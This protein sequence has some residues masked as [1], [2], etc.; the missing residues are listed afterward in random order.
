MASIE[1]QDKNTQTAFVKEDFIQTNKA[2]PPFNLK[3]EIEK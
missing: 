2:Q 3:N 1:R